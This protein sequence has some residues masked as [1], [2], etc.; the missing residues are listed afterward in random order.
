MTKLFIQNSGVFLPAG[1]TLEEV[2]LKQK[3]WQDQKK[4]ALDTNVSLYKA[5][6]KIIKSL[7]DT[8][9]VMDSEQIRELEAVKEAEQFIKE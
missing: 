3:C 5:K 1:I 7:I 4:I 9:E 2:E 8:L 6:K